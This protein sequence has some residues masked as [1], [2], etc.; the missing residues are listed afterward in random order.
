[1]P[2]FASMSAAEGVIVTS[3]PARQAG[4]SGFVATSRLTMSV[5]GEPIP[6][7][8]PALPLVEYCEPLSGIHRLTLPALAVSPADTEQTSA[9]AIFTS[10]REAQLD[11]TNFGAA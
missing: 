2:T 9:T 4:G 1:M 5:A 6:S 8:P 10:R 11:A 3:T 7:T